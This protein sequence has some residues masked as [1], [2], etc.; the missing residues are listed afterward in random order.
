MTHIIQRS[1]NGKFMPVIIITLKGIIAKFNYMKSLGL[2]NALILDVLFPLH[3][4][5]VKLLSF[6]FFI[7]PFS[8]IP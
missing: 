1:D 2:K 5:K 7:T 6:Y 8:V 3:F 4:S